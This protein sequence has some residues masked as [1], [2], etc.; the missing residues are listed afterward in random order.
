MELQRARELAEGLMATHRLRG[1]RLVFDNAKSRAGVCRSDSKQIGLSRP[2]VKIYDEA[3]VRDIVLHEIAHALVGARHGHDRVWR[4][5][6]LR[7]GCSGT[8]C[9]PE[10]APKLEGAWTGVC[11]SGHRTTAHRRPV[12]VR[13]CPACSP[14]FDAAAVYDW[15]HRGLPAEMHPRYVAELA[16]IRG[17]ATR[18]PQHHAQVGDRVRVLGGGRYG[19]LVG[20]VV[21]RGRT[22]YHVQTR[23]GVL[24]ASFTLVEPVESTAQGW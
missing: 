1:W 7:I 8:R 19:G 12:R 10:D 21:K 22:R 4:A 23:A 17:R 5:T 3:Q 15:T 18:P 20:T 24:T 16:R 14:S 9:M 11:P 6:A 2:L 13:S